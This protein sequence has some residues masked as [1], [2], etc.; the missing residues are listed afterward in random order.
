MLN[1]ARECREVRR[2]LD[3][4][5]SE[6]RQ[7]RADEVFEAI[8]EHRRAG[9]IPN[10]SILEMYEELVP[11]GHARVRAMREN[12]RMHGQSAVL[13]E[14]GG[15]AV[16]TANFSNIIGQIV[17]A[18]ILDNFENPDL[19]GS[20]LVTEMPAST[21]QKEILPGITMIG[22]VAQNVGETE[23]Y[24][25]VGVSGMHVTLPELIK[26][27]FILPVTEEAIYEDKTGQLMQN[28][29][30][31]A[32]QMALTQEKERL[33]VILGIENTYSRNDG[34]TQDTY[35]SSH[36]QGDFDN[37]LGSTPLTDYTSIEAAKNLFNDITDPDTGE[38][39]FI[40]G[41]MQIVTPDELEFTL[42]RVLNNVQLEQGTRS[43]SAPIAT[44][45]NPISTGRRSYTGY[46]SQYVS[47]VGSTTDSWWVGKFPE[48]FVER[49]IWPT[50][51][52]VEDR[53]SHAGF[54]RDIVTRVKCRRKT[55]TGV[56]EPRKVI[57][58]ISASE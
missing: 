35:A 44:F 36:T 13:Q 7:H 53:N 31:A 23:E 5:L 15:D 42:A 22:D 27:G 18:D 14:A 28:V 38:P 46:S 8:H 16:S 17:F 24:P 40:G 54:S 32:S 58:V 2:E 48:A 34:P 37:L 45:S 52:F 3:S 26:D 4:H 56:K 43:A 9:E 49:V 55:R 6:G 39:I 41:S 1:T 10:F 20:S 47:S 29:N 12:R 51:V 50:Q 30:D 25:Y 11:E 19:I 33:G 21:Q 57:K